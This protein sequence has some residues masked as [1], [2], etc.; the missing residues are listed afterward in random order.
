MSNPCFI[1]IEDI[2]GDKFILN[3]NFISHIHV[4]GEGSLV[5]LFEQN[6]HKQPYVKTKDSYEKIANEIS[7]VTGGYGLRRR[8][9]D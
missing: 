3:L 1:E 4:N 5:H 6:P 2:H 8:S 9:N 7:F